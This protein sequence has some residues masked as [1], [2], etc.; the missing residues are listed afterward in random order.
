MIHTSCNIQRENNVWYVKR[1]TISVIRFP[2][3][4]SPERM[5]KNLHWNNGFVIFIAVIFSNCFIT[6]TI[7]P[8]KTKNK[9]YTQ[10]KPKRNQTK[11]RKRI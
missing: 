10:K 8:M 5:K 11:N 9:N 6:L 2:C 1:G 4:L 7:F 3:A